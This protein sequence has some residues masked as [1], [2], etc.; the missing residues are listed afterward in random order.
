MEWAGTEL[1]RKLKSCQGY[2]PQ[3]IFI[4]WWGGGG[5]AAEKRKRLWMGH[6]LG[7][8]KVLERIR[9]VCG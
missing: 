3:D 9:K 4:L 1:P 7:K 8:K 5:F 2:L 6:V